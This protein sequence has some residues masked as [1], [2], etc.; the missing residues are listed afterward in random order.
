M[1]FTKCFRVQHIFQ[2]PAKT[3]KFCHIEDN[4]NILDGKVRISF[5]EVLA[6]VLHGTDD[7]GY[8]FNSERPR[9]LVDCI[10][11]FQSIGETS[12]Q[13]DRQ[14]EH[15]K[16]QEDVRPE[17]VPVM[18]VVRVEVCQCCVVLEYGSVFS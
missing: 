13:E 9:H 7:L 16:A 11:H 5:R 2:L 17:N 6:Q 3:N 12:H 4:L 15:D 18:F 10:S 14:G 1:L 8:I